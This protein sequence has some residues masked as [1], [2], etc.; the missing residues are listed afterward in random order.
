MI[1]RIKNILY[2]TDLSENSTYAFRYALNSA[3]MHGAKI[4]I[5]YVLKPKFI[6]MY[7]DV[8][9]EVGPEPKE[10]IAKIKKRLNVLLQE[11]SK[12]NP[13]R[14]KLVSTIEVIEGDPVVKILEK[15]DQM[16]PDVI[17]MGTHSKGFIAQTFL[18]SVAQNVLQHSRIP[19]YVIPLPKK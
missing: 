17:I 8:M 19:V 10:V 7:P 4:H 6:G 15:A 1:P 16:N 13:D 5:L 3:E 12:D 9:V 18:G 11:E 2:T 14:A